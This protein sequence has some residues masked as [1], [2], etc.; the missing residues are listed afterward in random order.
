VLHP[1]TTLRASIICDV[2]QLFHYRFA[3][4]IFNSHFVVKRGHL[5]DTRTIGLELTNQ[6]LI[7]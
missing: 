3:F 5:V 6:I 2:A 1:D 7:R 4:V